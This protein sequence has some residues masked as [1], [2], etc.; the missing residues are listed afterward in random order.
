VTKE[1]ISRCLTTSSTKYVIAKFDLR[2]TYK[3]CLVFSSDLI[4]KLKNR[5]ASLCSTLT[6]T[7]DPPLSHVPVFGGYLGAVQTGLRKRRTDRSS[8]LSGTSSSVSMNAA[9]R[10][11]YHMRSADHITDALASLHWLRVPERIEYKVAVLTYKVL[12]GS[13]PR[14]LG[15]PTPVADLP[16]SRT[17]LST[18]TNHLLVPSVRH[19]TV[20]NRAFTVAG[21]HVWNTLPE[22]ITTPQSL[23]MFCRHFKT[24]LFRKSCPDII[25]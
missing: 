9:A 20:G 19:S 7:S 4:M 12:H 5:V 25:V 17:L 3:M 13:A 16:G 22:D 11:I 23:T 18:G 2:L 15:P 24:W 1:S 14:Y 10:L 21:P 6:I 8:G